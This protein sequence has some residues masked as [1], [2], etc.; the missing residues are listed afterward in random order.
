MMECG[1]A[2]VDPARCS[3]YNSS[4][5]FPGHVVEGGTCS[6]LD[7][8]I[9]GIVMLMLAGWVGSGLADFRTAISGPSD[10]PDEKVY[11]SGWP[12]WALSETRMWA[13]PATLSGKGW[14]LGSNV[15][16]GHWLSGV[17]NKH[18]PYQ[19]RRSS[20]ARRSERRTCTSG[21]RMVFGW[22]TPDLATSFLTLINHF[23][24]RTYENHIL[25]EDPC[26][27]GLPS[28]RIG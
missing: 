26:V 17:G 1:R 24:I 27:G 9:H 11:I 10:G 19:P 20:G 22:S 21:L 4:P 14:P 28:R 13:G 12:G 8:K 6:D 18:R 25:T 16:G 5:G 23:C 15:T 2:V 3:E 7:S